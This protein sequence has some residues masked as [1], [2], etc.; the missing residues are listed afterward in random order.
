M[1]VL[2]KKVTN[3]CQLRQFVQFAC[4]L[5]KGDPYYCPPLF[6]DEMNTFDPKKNPAHEI[7]NCQLFLA[8]K[9]NQ[10]CGRIAGIINY[11]ANE[12]WKKQRCRFGWFDFIDDFEVF[13]ALLDAVSAWGKEK[14]MTEING[15]V[16]FTDFDHQGLLIE[17]YDYNSPMASL[18]NFPYYV[19]LY[20]QYGLE[21]EVDWIEYQV[22]PPKEI[23][24]RMSRISEIVTERS[25]VKVV[26]VKNF[27]ELVK[28]YGYTYLDVIDEAYQPLYNF[29]PLTEAQK[30]YYC[31]MYFP[32]LNFDFVTLLANEKDELVGVGVGMPSLS[33]ALR[34][35]DGKLFPF[36]WFHVYR[37]L[38]AKKMSDFDLLLIAVRPDY[39]DKGVN[40]LFFVDQASVFRQYGI[41]RVETT[42][43]LETNDKNQANFKLFDKIQHKR[44][45]A[46]VKS[47]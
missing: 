26:K 12:A 34:K 37:A 5:F 46:Y 47:L 16:G 1:A 22:H 8:F 20:E 45:R 36:G 43:I 44:R 31:K 23:P 24:E 18:Y 25:K 4:D 30:E 14:G 17:G 40:A 32:L 7:S 9:D 28:R 6:Y 11:R 13:K 27:K 39:Q 41:Q 29:Q 21:K 2:I 3:K 19:K 35:C 10:V 38:K 15:P 33:E 42:A